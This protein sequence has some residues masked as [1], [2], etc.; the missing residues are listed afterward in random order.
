MDDATSG[1]DE[2]WAEQQSR[3]G[4]WRKLP[5]ARNG[6]WLVTS[7]TLRTSLPVR[8]LDVRRQHQRLLGV[9]RV[10]GHGSVSI[11]TPLP[12]DDFLLGN[13]ETEDSM[14]NVMDVMGDDFIHLATLM[15]TSTEP[16]RFYIPFCLA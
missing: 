7:D 13:M 2:S 12:I 6:K 15:T 14:S 10:T 3:L 4:G 16:T 8:R 1:N 9:T 11:I 5:D